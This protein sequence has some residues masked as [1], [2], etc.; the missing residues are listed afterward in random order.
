M[1][2]SRTVKMSDPW[3]MSSTGIGSILYQI[4]RYEFHDFRMCIC[5]VRCSQKGV[6]MISVVYF[7]CFIDHMGPIHTKP[8]RW[9]SYNMYIWI[10][11]L[12]IKD[13]INM[14]PDSGNARAAHTRPG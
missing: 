11:S 6:E 8:D 1:L 3:A 9:A 10:C 14:L 5:A 7:E 4:L 13:S 2:P 12:E